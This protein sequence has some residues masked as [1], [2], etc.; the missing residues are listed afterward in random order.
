MFFSRRIKSLARQTSNN[1]PG[2]PR[3]NKR[4]STCLR[5]E[6][7]EGRIVMDSTNI[8]VVQR[9][10]NDLFQRPADSSGLQ[11]W[12]S[13]LDAGASK[14]QV[15][16]G[17]LDSTEYRLDQVDV[18]FWKLLKRGLDPQSAGSF[19]H[20]LASGGNIE[21]VQAILLGSPEYLQRSGG[22]RA[23]FLASLF[24]DVLGRDIDPIARDTFTRA[25]DNGVSRTDVAAV[26]LGSPEARGQLIQQTY[27]RYLDR[28]AEDAA[29]SF[30]TSSLEAGTNQDEI[31][32]RIL[33]SQEYFNRFVATPAPPMTDRNALV[34]PG[35]SQD[36]ITATFSVAAADTTFENEF[37]IFP[38]ADASGRIGA[39]MPGD[40]GYDAAALSESGQRTV[41]TQGFAPG[42]VTSIALPGGSFVGL[43]LVQNSSTAQA[44]DSNPNNLASERPLVFFSFASANP[45][46][47]D[48]LQQTGANHF[49]FEDLF[50]GGDRDFND[51]AVRVDFTQSSSGEPDQTPPTVQLT[52]PAAGLLTNLNPVISGQAEDDKSGLASVEAEVDGGAPFAISFDAAGRFNVPTTLALDGSADGDHTVAVRA[53]DKAGNVSNLVSAS[54]TLDTVAPAVDFHLDPATDTA[55]EGDGHTE[56][57]AITLTGATEPNT[58][59][60]LHETGAS[61]ISDPTT[62]AFSF[63]GISLALG[64]NSFTVLATDRAGNVGE[65]QH[66][67]TREAQLTGT[68]LTEDSR[69]LTSL[70]QTIVVPAQPAKL[71]FQFSS[72]NFD[73]RSHFIKDAFEASLTDASGN[74]LLLPITNSRDAFLNITEGQP[75]V[76]SPNVQLN[77]STVDVDL[78]HIPAGTQAR[79]RVRLV[80]N[81]SDTT[82]SVLVSSADIIDATMNTPAAVTPAADFVSASNTVDFSA[83]AD[84]SSSMAANYAR[85]S[86]N[87]TNDVLFAGLSVTN[88]GSYLVDSPLLVAVAHISDPAVHPRHIDGVTP[89]GLP[90]YDFSKLVNGNT[91][92]PG[93][94][95]GART[96]EFFDPQG[97][98]F[99]YDLVVL[100]HLNRSPAFTSDPDVEAIIGKPYIYEARAADPDNDSLTFS[101]VTGPAGMTVDPA[102]GKVS[103]NPQQGDLGNQAV[104]LKVDDGHGGTAI[105]SYTVSAVAAPPNRPPVFT[106]SPVVDA[107]VATTYLYQAT[108]TDA[109]GDALTFS[110]EAGPVNLSI[111][112][113]SGRVTWTPSAAQLGTNAVTLK[114]DDGHGG[115]VI[116]TY[117]VNVQQLAG[118]RPPAIVSQPETNLLP[119]QAYTYP[120]HAIDPDNDPLTYSLVTFPRGMTIDSKS[121]F[122]NWGAPALQLSGGNYVITPDLKSALPTSSVTLELWFNASG[123]GVLV[124]ELGTTVLNS[125]FHDSQLEIVGTQVIA[126]V[127]PLTPVV[128]GNITF[129]TWHQVTLRYDGS[130]NTLDGFLD[131]VKSATASSGARLVPTAQFYALGAGDSTN[132]GSGAFLNGQIAEFRVWKN[133]RNDSQITDNEH[134]RLTG[135]ESGLAAYYHFD[136]GTGTIAHDSSG[137]GNDATFAAV[138]PAALPI[139]VFPVPPF[140]PA[141]NQATVR[142][143]DGRGGFDTQ[144]FTI[145]LTDGLPGAIAGTVFDDRNG[146]G[147]R[148]P[149]NDLPALPASHLL[150]L[151]GTADPYLAGMPDGSIADAGD[152]APAVSPLEVPGLTL[153]GGDSLMF[154]SPAGGVRENAIDLLNGAD[155]G[156]ITIHTAGALNGISAIEAPVDSLVGVFLGPDQPD[157]SAA[158]PELDFNRNDP[159]SVAGG[160]D[161]AS[162]A[163]LLKQTFFIGDGRTSAGQV[164]Q[165]VIPAGA[166]R[167]FLASMSTS[168]WNDN[169]GSFA[170]DVE[171]F[172]PST[173]PELAKLV[174]ISTN[175]N[176]P[177]SVDFDEPLNALV[178]SVNFGSNGTPRNFEVIQSDGTHVPFGNV[179]GLGNEV[180]IATARSGN[181]GGFTPGDLFVGNGVPGQIARLSDG[182]NTL[183]NPWA[184]LPGETGLL[185]GGL[186]FDQTGIYGGNLIVDTTEGGI[187]EIDANG[188]ATKL[189]STGTFLEAVATVPNDAVRYGPLAGKVVALDEQGTKIF[190]VDTG[191][192]VASIDLNLPAL[193]TIH[194][195]P[196]NE[197]FFGVDF[198]GSRLLGASAAG[199]NSMVGDILLTQEANTVPIRLVWDG[200]DFLSQPLNMAP[201]SVTP[202]GWEGSAFTGTAGVNEI[203]PIDLEPG[204]P[205]WTVYLDLNQNGK[206]DPDEPFTVTDAKG[207]YSFSNLVPGTYTVALEGQQGFQTTLPTSAFYT[208]ALQAGQSVS[209][210]DFGTTAVTPEQHAPKFTSTPPTRTTAGQQLHYQ[211]TVSNPDGRPLVFDLPVRPDGMVVDPD[212]GEVVWT[213]SVTEFG[214]QK[215][216]LRVRD[217]RGNVDLQAFTLRVAL[218]NFA[219]VI[220]SSPSLSALVGLPYQYQVLAQDAE[221]D[222]LSYQLTTFPLGMLIDPAT[223][224]LTYIPT[225]D[226]L[227]TQT[228]TIQVSDGQGGLTTQSFSLVVEATAANHLPIIASS[229]RTTVGI[230]QVY[231]YQVTAID[232][233]ADPL[234]ITLA[235][236]PTGMSIDSAGLI[237]WQ[238]AAGQLGANAVEVVV[239]DD[240]G[241][242]VTQDFTITVNAQAN[243]Q[244]PQ[245]VSTPNSSGAVN[246]PYQYDAVAHDPDN[247]PIVWD[248]VEAP[249]GMSLNLNLGTLRW[250]PT[251][252]QIGAQH[253]VLRATDNFGASAIQSFTIFVQSA[254]R[255]PVILSSPPTNAAQSHL[256]TY[257]VQASDADH[258]PLTFLLTTAPSGMQ[259]DPATGII[260]WTPAADEAGNQGVALRVEDG[261]GGN[262]TQTWSVLVSDTLQNLPPVITSTPPLAPSAG[263]AYQYQVTAVDPDGPAPTFSLLI[264]PAGMTID[265]VSGLVQWTPTAAQAG[266][267]NVT[268]VATDDQGASAVQTFG[269]V[270]ILGGNQAPAIASSPSTSAAPGLTYHYDVHASDPDGDLLSYVLNASPAGMSIDPLGR[271]A[272]S[273]QASDI[274]NQPVS[275]SVSDGRGGIATQSFTITVAADTEAPQVSL[276]LSANPADLGAS[277]LV[278]LS[279]TDNV[280]VTGL[281]LTE[282]GVAVAID[283][284]GHAIIPADHFGSFVLEARASD[285][286]GNVGTDSQTLVVRD[287]RVI[288]APIVDLTAPT[289]DATIS[290]PT[291]IVGTVQDPS[292]VSYTLD[293]APPD[294]DAFTTFFTGTS[295]VTNGVLGTFDP[296]LLQ[297]DSYVLRLTATN[298]GG[299]SSSVE[300][301]LNVS[302]NLKLGN[303]T[304]SFTDL[305]VPVAGV[306]I[307]VTRSYD[308]LNASNSDDFGFG[309]RL[310]FRDVDLRTGVVKT[311]NEA[312]GFFNPFK[313]GT[314]VYLTLP[315]GKREGFTFQP[316]LAAGLRGSFI[317]IF[318]PTFVPDAGVTDSLTVDPADLRFAEDGSVYDFETGLAYNP[319]DPNFGGSYLLT[320]QAGIAYSIDGITGQ[321]TEASDTNNNTLTF[322]E[323]GIVSSTGVSIAFERDAQGRINAIVDP[324]GKTL[325]YQYDANGDLVAVTD[326]S[327]N[328]TQFVYLSNP[329][330]YLSKV[331]DPLGRTGVRADYNAQGQLIALVNAAGHAVQLA[332]DVH[333]SLMSTTDPLGNTTTYI[334]DDRGNALKEIDPL[335]AVTLRTFDADNN[336]LTQTDPLGRTTSYTY[337][338]RGDML[339]VT[340]PLGSTT[341]NTYQAFTFGIT[342]LAASRGEAAAPFTRIATSTDPL[343]NTTT[344]GY[345][346]FGN[347]AAQK[348]PLGNTTTIVNFATERPAVITDP[349][350][351]VT[352]DQYDGSGYL[353]QSVDADGHVTNFSNDADGNLLTQAQADGSGW[354]LSYNANGTPTSI[355]VIG[356]AHTVQ[357]DAANQMTQLTD[358]SGQTF[359]YSYDELGQ[360]TQVKLPDA[361]I[362]QTRTYDAAGNLI[363]VTDSLN[364]VTRY[365]YDAD[366]RLLQTVYPDGSTELQTFDLAGE[367]T[368]VTDQLGDTTHY[369][370]D[371]AGRQIQTVDALGGITSTQYDTA[372]R[373]VAT[374]DP[375][376]RITRFRYDAAG[377]LLATSAPD[378][379]TTR[380][381]Y[382]AD[383]RVV[384]IVDAA[385][386]VTTNGYDPNGNL[387]S[388]TD[389]LGNVTSYQYGAADE[390]TAVVDALGNI[391]RYRYDTQGHVLKTTQANGETDSS[392][393]DSAGRLASTTNGNNETIRY[394]YDALNRLTSRTLPGGSQE[395]YTYTSDGLISSVTDASGTTRYDYD[396]IMRRLVRVTQPDGRYIRYAYDGRGERTLMADSMAAGSPEDVTQYAYDALGRL[397][398]VTDPQGGITSYTYDADGNL[399]TTSLPNGVTETDAYDSLNRVIEILAKNSAGAT[400][401]DFAYT[402]DANGNRTK[403][404]DA[405]G[406]HHDY[407]YDALDRVIAEATFDSTGVSTGAETYV[408]DAMGNVTARSGSLLGNATFSY[409]GNNQLVSGAGST[410]TYDAAGRLASVTD[411]TGNVT[412]YSY[413]AR[414]RLVSLQDPDGSVTSYTYDYQGVRQSQQDAGGLVKYLVDEANGPGSAQVVRETDSTGVTLRSYVVGAR[415]LSVSQG[416]DLRFYLSDGL[417]STRLLTNQTGAVTDTYRYSAY[418]VLLEHTGG[419]ANAFQFAGQQQDA[420]GL[421]YLRARY[422]DP[423]TGR[424]LSRDAYAASDQIPL[425]LNKYLYA[426]ANPVNDTDPSGNETLEE[427]AIAED[428]E[429]EEEKQ[430]AAENVERFKQIT[431]QIFQEDGALL[432]AIAFSR[433]LEDPVQIG[434]F[435]GGLL[436][437]DLAST[438]FGIEGEFWLARIGIAMATNL[439]IK[440]RF[441]DKPS[442]GP[443]TLAYVLRG[444]PNNIYVCAAL[445]P[446]LSRPFPLVNHPLRTSVAGTLVHEFAHL[447]SKLYITDSR[448]ANSYGINCLEFP[449]HDALRNAQNYAFAI[450]A[451]SMGRSAEEAAAGLLS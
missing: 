269:I 443:D 295:P 39:L 207:A 356:L 151:L 176:T 245:I 54:F 318:E 160:I 451:V 366:N 391:T 158:P 348:D 6:E 428:I 438:G 175:F 169:V 330:H 83:L 61:S 203:S 322:S 375:L 229:P 284:S 323:A 433:G 440:Y 64:D 214:P 94:T 161:Y 402:L 376:G 31:L 425:S 195:V 71:E 278:S 97:S 148:D 414:G 46:R 206:R 28:A 311:G 51:F 15:A 30:W 123:P 109:D 187:W 285:A 24:H 281:T 429:A 218:K 274:G 101:L 430:D 236:A 232:P 182:G 120:V 35:S 320:T 250:T 104:L 112:S 383:G 60:V 224:L 8:Q 144:S 241:G 25:L 225:A 40:P 106:S 399:T 272:W 262:A 344:N 364:N 188:K 368:A 124:D 58:S 268:I 398:Q 437:P 432:T 403:E 252:D 93:Q 138:S 134:Q 212:T 367:L 253:V 76:L 89:D 297:N 18:T 339:T 91:L 415:L 251:P 147:K 434:R 110:V 441:D 202:I 244:A 416:V 259:I 53:T 62:G 29:V 396:P 172:D 380:E 115:T 312:D 341:L 237:R 319:A 209:P 10:F 163:P 371:A 95:T 164:Q 332:Y 363:T 260:Q 413:D 362:A 223:G 157:L 105:Q 14:G 300:T 99:T 34:V 48:H 215:V 67:V 271:I 406:S 140:S 247:D 153:V 370:Y 41:F 342:A 186:T 90:Y 436:L 73:T 257:A 117:D 404:D 133:A 9:Y 301:T 184:T 16:L 282:D 149:L 197:N 439:K 422:Y 127:F 279:A 381:V 305:T 132:V 142:V 358:P 346:F 340:D 321:L 423:A 192:N 122:I 412:R 316:T 55:P 427:E 13:G 314:H 49:T 42:A 199:F 334:Y 75:A 277:V 307:S 351:N 114:V 19:D 333:N 88:I 289:G 205:N 139:W 125:T 420:S 325:H 146:D 208:V 249:D 331:I 326:R 248:L 294:S 155:G 154:T 369:A 276:R 45:D 130:T 377:R 113:A 349:L 417:G 328:T 135:A 36:T 354:S 100:G 388:V 405:D 78:S 143:D 266:T 372:G 201:G 226:Q 128:L 267:N 256:Y 221:S 121:G 350:G 243:N 191:G 12:S 190:T 50:G 72:L 198:D 233:D 82:T 395:T 63:T 177:I 170:V 234:S 98:Q 303:F 444:D 150:N 189:G 352:R 306:P 273:P 302:Q 327:N 389:A 447:V 410:Y 210:L 308:T 361:T 4:S 235:T 329:A 74:S 220:T 213:A 196:G 280:E 194:V 200:K 449:P 386:N 384:Q 288:G 258:D 2:R 103:W 185:R 27:L 287:P 70:D 401:S 421:L 394:S 159:N 152:S 400:I 32:V 68:R 283:A 178:L 424:F 290:A 291:D 385:G 392:T 56:F 446:Y 442:T 390:R 238:P 379:S 397:V 131:G 409:N 17:I 450:L 57:A 448:G 3:K 254:N 373:P 180:Y 77:G 156:F 66:Q 343:G 37:G 179:S 228:V 65:S 337:D 87:E 298:T 204:L 59:V 255:P 286:V 315:G 193:E 116:Q 26:V 347:L 407:T 92:L 309:W 7:L 382:D 174:P 136:E 261:R 173:A 183:I 166:T 240:R 365:K 360:M 22:G 335:G 118:N 165:V 145:Q 419:S 162:L 81:D 426:L 310:G 21:Q 80:N 137:N 52:S 181:L 47:F 111:D 293:F 119:S 345:D 211:A 96:L 107:N 378:S 84:V 304:L 313:N 85:T 299:L 168:A 411:T 359:L 336:M 102:S 33:G 263:Q 264:G 219:P 246:Q 216:I 1:L 69:F 5:I 239:D 222:P 20:F 108:A 167:L 141:S 355:G 387:V 79:L 317:G 38:V 227:G 171:P 296:T 324:M 374:T 357:Y 445:L 217:D 43:Y 270:V 242:V 231:L 11:F 431:F 23:Q 126:R 292:L 393:Y 418:G 353:T 230:G 275:V 86:L 338:D 44:R 435:L 129:G 265:P 408:Y